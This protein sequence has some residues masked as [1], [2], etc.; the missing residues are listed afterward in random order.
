MSEWRE[1]SKSFANRAWSYEHATLFDLISLARGNANAMIVALDH[2]TDVG[3]LGA[4]IRTAEVAGAIGVVIP[5]KR[6]AQVTEAVYRSSAGA[7]EYIKVAREPN[8]AAAIRRL[9]EEGFWVG[10]ATEHAKQSIWE[11]PLD[12]RLVVVLGA[13]DTG[14]SR[15]T[16]ELCDFEFKVPQFGL[17]PSLNVTQAF[18][19]IAYEHL[20]RIHGATAR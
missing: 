14:L 2:I 16:R 8:L 6:A 19:V 4:I 17:T 5:S 15:L 3:N 7:V 1:E 9:K 20:R 13:E 18:S 12:G 11:A 10:G